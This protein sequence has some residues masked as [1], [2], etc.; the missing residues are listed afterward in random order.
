MKRFAKK[1]MAALLLTALM[2]PL[3]VLGMTSCS[4][5]AR[6]NRMEE[7]ERA[8]AFMKLVN[9]TMD[10]QSGYTTQQTANMLV[11]VYGV[12]VEI[13]A[14]AVMTVCAPSAEDY[15]IHTESRNIMTMDDESV[16]A[17]AIEG[18]ADGKMF[19]YYAEEGQKTTKLW[20]SVTAEEY[21]VYET[22][23]SNT[24]DLDDEDVV[25]HAATR[26]CVQNEDK[27]WT[28]TFTDYSAEGIKLFD[29]LL[30]GMEDYISDAC[31]ADVIMTV[32][33]D[34]NF[35]PTALTVEFVFELTED[36]DEE[37]ILPELTVSATYRDI[38]TAQPF[39][40]DLTGYT[41][42]DDLRVAAIVGNT[43]EDFKDAD[44]AEFRMVFNQS[45]EAGGET[46]SY[47]ERTDGT[48]EI[49]DDGYTYELSSRIDGDTYIIRYENG[50]QYVSLGTQ[51]ETTPC[52]EAQAKDFIESLLDPAYY[53][54]YQVRNIEKVEE[55]TEKGETTY[56]LTLREP[57]LSQYESSLGVYLTGEAS[58]EATIS[59]GRMT[60]QSYTLTMNSGS[61]YKIELNYKCYYVSF[62]NNETAE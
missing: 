43:L 8:V 29:G 10:A 33:A 61:D 24:T 34:K 55:D 12:Q 14:E 54:S 26:T 20:S 22:E 60:E 25:N 2:I 15:F 56:R 16:E 44:K 4:E 58:I 5:G 37:A 62:E 46:Q 17:T 36:A 59:D 11:E 39:E 57:D 9:Q 3:T 7:S 40:V 53:T 42:V 38:G 35:L 27:S 47:Y 6:L 28:A 41:E 23:T 52:T 30:A 31:V 13:K 50:K 51:Q 1:T 49:T 32:K 18:Y 19:S 48:V 21:K 45:V